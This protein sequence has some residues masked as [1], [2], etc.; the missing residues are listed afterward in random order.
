MA[1]T[2]LPW[3]LNRL[4]LKIKITTIFNNN[5]TIR[6]LYFA[7]TQNKRSQSIVSMLHIKEFIQVYLPLVGRAL[8][9][10]GYLLERYGDVEPPVP[11][12]VVLVGHL[13]VLSD[14]RTLAPGTSRTLFVN[15]LL[16]LSNVLVF[17]YD[18]IIALWFDVPITKKRE[19][20]ETA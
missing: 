1:Y 13:C 11:S 9:A 17:L 4:P 6:G 16:F 8:M 19:E 3:L 5:I 12:A 18:F 2:R 10:L 15:L 14:P 7:F 20:A